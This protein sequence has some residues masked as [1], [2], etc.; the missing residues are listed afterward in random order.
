VARD[1]D[2]ISPELMRSIEEDDR[3]W[4]RLVESGRARAEA[5]GLT[6]DDVPRLV[7]DAR[8]DRRPS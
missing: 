8:R 2:P 6:E 7:A 5:R 3:K 1:K 4:V